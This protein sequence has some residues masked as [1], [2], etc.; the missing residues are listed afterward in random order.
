MGKIT[1]ILKEE[2]AKKYLN[3]K[4]LLTS[5]SLSSEKSK[6]QLNPQIQWQENCTNLLKNN[7]KSHSVK[8]KSLRFL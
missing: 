1:S 3:F 8:Q 5:N 6:N 4:R 2:L 7:Q